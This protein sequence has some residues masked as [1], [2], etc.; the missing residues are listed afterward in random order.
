[1]TNRNN[2]KLIERIA[3]LLAAREN[4]ERTGNTEWHIRHTQALHDLEKLLPSGSGFDCG[5]K[6]DLDASRPDCLRFTT[7]FHHMDEHGFYDGWTSHTVIVRPSFVYGMDIRVMGR[8]R[9]GIKELI[10]E[11]FMDALQQVAP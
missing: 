6:L 4:C 7:E 2:T 3:S 10:H 9:N 8:D 5:S 1:M 11:V